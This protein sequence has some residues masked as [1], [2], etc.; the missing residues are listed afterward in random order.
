[1]RALAAFMMFGVGV[2]VLSTCTRSS[3]AN[4]QPSES[5]RRDLLWI[6]YLGKF[7]SF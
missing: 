7:V 1:M 6:S 2:K 5:E 3:Q 4:R